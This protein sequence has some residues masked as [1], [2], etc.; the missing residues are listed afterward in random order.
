[1]IA[2]LSR[3]TSA[4]NLILLDKVCDLIPIVS[5]VTNLI[6][7]FEKC[8]FKFCSAETIKNNHYY[9]HINDKS[10]VQCLALIFIPFIS[11]CVIAVY[12]LVKKENPVQIANQSTPT[13]F[14]NQE[15]QLTPIPAPTTTVNVTIN[16]VAEDPSIRELKEAKAWVLIMNDVFTFTSHFFDLDQMERQ[17][18]LNLAME[19]KEYLKKN[20]KGMEVLTCV[21]ARDEQGNDGVNLEVLP[22][23]LADYLPNLKKIDIRGHS[24]I[25]FPACIVN[26]PKLEKINFALG[27]DENHLQIP[28]SFGLLSQLREVTIFFPTGSKSTISLP[29]TIKNLK[30]L[31]KLYLYGL[32]FIPDEIGEVDNLEA[33]N[34]SGLRYFPNKLLKLKKLTW[35]QIQDVSSILLPDDIFEKMPKI[36]HIICKGGKDFLRGRDFG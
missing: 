16:A 25:E 11:N 9:T 14:I 22:S 17:D 18:I 31:T 35:L 21:R 2:S 26:F 12:N 28:D 4:Q 33:L 13:N 1:M 6:V 10:L 19:A 32:E 24:L 30:N 27:N 3:I 20:R 5:S 29:K 8:V 7:L 23:D 15:P 34:M 36:S